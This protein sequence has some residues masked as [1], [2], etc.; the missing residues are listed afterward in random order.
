[1]S[2]MSPNILKGV[3][4][5]MGRNSIV[6]KRKNFWTLCKNFAWKFTVTEKS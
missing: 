1:M 6:K 4:R 5:M 2:F 3:L